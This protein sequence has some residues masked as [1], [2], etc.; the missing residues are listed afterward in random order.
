M[1][2]PILDPRLLTAADF[3]PYCECGADI[4]ADHGHLSCYL[5]TCGKCKTMQV[6]DISE[7]SLQKARA[8]LARHG[9]TDRASFLCGDGLNT[10]THPANAIAICGMGGHTLA[11]ILKSGSDKLAGASL[12]LS[13]QTEH[14][15][16]RQVLYHDLGY[17]LER[18][19]VVRAAGRYYVMMLSVPGERALTEREAY[20]GPCLMQCATED[21]LAYVKWRC[22]VVAREQHY[23]ADMYRLWLREEYDRVQKAIDS[24]GC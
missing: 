15:L 17:H 13:P 23:A 18:E 6:T 1:L 3:F 9:F 14:A 4:G 2:K 10:L 5:L 8:L 22:D 19:Q 11:D 16:V 12:I 20:L 24:I 7:A 21:Y